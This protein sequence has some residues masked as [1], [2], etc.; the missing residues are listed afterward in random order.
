M[1]SVSAANPGLSN[2]LQTL[3]NIDSPLLTSPSAL[4]AIE[5]SSPADIVKL[6]AAATQLQ[7]VGAIFGDGQTTPDSL[8]PSGTSTFT[9][10]E[11]ALTNSATASF[12]GSTANTTPTSE[13][14]ALQSSLQTA[15]ADALLNP[16][17]TSST[18]NSLF[19]VL[20]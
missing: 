15:E 20:G 6:S 17:T 1:S 18:T 4:T 7:E 8:L 5:N 3:S 10:L 12:T 2:L 19:S 11:N 14:P 9:A 13:L 16:G